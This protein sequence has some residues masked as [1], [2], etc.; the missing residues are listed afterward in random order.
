[1]SLKALGSISSCI[2][3]K[4]GLHGTSSFLAPQHTIPG[5]NEILLSDTQDIKWLKVAL[6]PS[7]K[8]VRGP[9]SWMLNPHLPTR[10]GRWGVWVLIALCSNG[11]DSR[12]SKWYQKKFWKS[13]VCIFKRA[14][15]KV[16]KG[17]ISCHYSGMLAVVL[18]AQKGLRTLHAL[19][20]FYALR[21]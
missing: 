1:M 11:S 2:C 6:S 7:M 15:G 19:F 3:R 20:L 13:S 4:W 9:G 16:D 21:I 12:L 17:H 10:S 8:V 18:F 14:G 5:S